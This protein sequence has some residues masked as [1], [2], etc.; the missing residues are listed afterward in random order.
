MTKIQLKRSSVVDGGSA[1]EPTA[2]QMEYGELAVNYSSQDPAIFIKDSNNDII[3][4]AGADAIGG[5][6]PSGGSGDRPNPPTI[7]DLYFDTDLDLILY[8][9]GSEWVPVGDGAYVKVAGDNMT[10]TLTIGPE[11]GPAKTTLNADGSAAFAGKATSAS[12]SAAD[13]GTTLVT[14]DYVDGSAVTPGDGALTIK[15]SG[16]DSGTGTFTANQSGNS[17]ITLPAIPYSDIT[18]TPAIPAPAGAGTITITQPGSPNQTF[19]VNQSGDTT[20]ALKNDNTVTTPGDGALTIQTSGGDAAT[21]TFTANQSGASTI[22]LP[23]ISYSDLTDVPPN[24]AAP[25]NGALTI[26]TSGGD[27]A[28]GTFTANQSGASTIKLPPIS[29]SDLVDVPPDAAAPGNGELILQTSAGDRAT[30][31]FTAN[32]NSA[33]ILILPAI[34]YSD[35]TNKPNIPTVPT[36]GNGTITITQPGTTSQTFTVNQTGDT[37]IALKNDNTVVTPGNGALTIETSGGDEATGTFTANQSGASTITLPPIDYKDLTGKPS[38]PAP[39]GAGTI[40]ITQPGS[41]DQTFNVNQSGDTTVVLKNDNTQTTPGNGALTIRTSGGD[42]ATGSF[43]ANQS[44]GST[45]TLP[46]IDYNDLTGKPSIPAAAGNG[47]ITIKQP[48]TTD[49]SFTVNQ[50]GN[51]TINLRND[52]TVTTPGNGALTIR[53]SGG[54]TATGSFTANQSTASTITLPAIPYSDIT[55]K[56]DIPSVG[57]GTITIKQPGTTDQTFNVN[58]G[59][60][61]T[62]NL[63]NDN[64][65]VTPGN[66]AINFNAGNGLTSTGSNATANQSTASTKTFSVE[67][68][69]NTISVGSSGISVNTSALPSAPGTNLGTSTSTTKVTITSSTGN[70]TDILAASSSKAGVMTTSQY[71]TLYGA[72]QRSGGTMTGDLILGSSAPLIKT[73]G[74]NNAGISGAANQ[75]VGLYSNHV[76]QQQSIRMVYQGAELSHNGNGVPGIDYQGGGRIGMQWHAPRVDF[77]VN[78]GSAGYVTLTASDVRLKNN[79]TSISE[80][81]LDYI[82]QLNPVSFTWIDPTFRYNAVDIEAGGDA[83]IRHGFIAD[84]V[85]SVIPQASATPAPTEE[86]PDPIKDYDDRTILAFLTKAVQELSAEN[87]ELKQRLDAAGL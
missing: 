80:G 32:Q 31:T 28:T 40:T 33:S 9:N 73:Q 24:A 46:A 23:P 1:K 60:N 48:G 45:L 13:S 21:G 38:I 49:Q 76:N 8:Y 42:T 17:T 30:G 16:G 69:D 3:R 75:A 81:A 44:T 64:T 14:K 50:S 20:I 71:S 53:T 6:L 87:T 66:G 25:G 67:A 78:T 74:T 18:G 79:I 26:E 22:T 43:T 83:L 85:I 72:L 56:P 36:V 65:V 70:N 59:G 5:E 12:T 57:A 27:A 82:N 37:T 51:T 10:G 35:L 54:D 11:G 39:A 19:N 52:N 34:D 77:H 68:A 55:G 41:P 15:T 58:Q 2:A 62:I 84:E 86:N 47:T 4:L 29:Y 63:K 7:G 61:T